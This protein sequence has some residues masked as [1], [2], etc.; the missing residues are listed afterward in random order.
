M[1]FSTY[2]FKS[3]TET[4]SVH[5]Y[6]CLVHIVHT[7][8]VWYLNRIL[9]IRPLVRRATYVSPVNCSSQSQ[10]SGRRPCGR[11]RTYWKDCVSPLAVKHW[12]P[13]KEAGE[14]KRTFWLLSLLYCQFIEPDRWIE[15]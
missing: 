9:C 8:L 1:L 5:P 12:S 4:K 15:M 2:L 10:L 14:G 11:P 7:I 3:D 13:P 6:S